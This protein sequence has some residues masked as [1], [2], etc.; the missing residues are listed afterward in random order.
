[1]CQLAKYKVVRKNRANWPIKPIS[2]EMMV[3]SWI[4]P[5]QSFLPQQTQEWGQGT[6]LPWSHSLLVS[7][8]VHTH[9][10]WQECPYVLYTQEKNKSHMQMTER[11]LGAIQILLNIFPSKNPKRAMERLFEC[12]Q[13]PETSDPLL[14]LKEKLGLVP[15]K[16]SPLL[17]ESSSNAGN[18]LD[19]KESGYEGYNRKRGCVWFLDIMMI[20]KQIA[21]GEGNLYPMQAQ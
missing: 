6:L 11:K 15:G 8:A 16:E 13:Y 17:L 18:C 5:H 10:K 7:V 20:S 14:I 12:F 21:V 9:K 4:L 1:M 2:K 19:I 3:L